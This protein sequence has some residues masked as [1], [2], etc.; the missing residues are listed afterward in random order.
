MIGLLARVALRPHRD[1]GRDRE[2]SDEERGS[3]GADRESEHGQKRAE[4]RREQPRAAEF[5]L[6]QKPAE[7]GAEL[8]TERHL[9]VERVD[10]GEE[11]GDPGCD[12]EDSCRDGCHIQRDIEGL[13][14]RLQ[15]EQG[16]DERPEQPGRSEVEDER[17]GR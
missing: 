3:P 17:R 10:E 14:A 9:G 1:E 16:Q 8:R 15:R 6:R 12:G 2:K 7:L 4:D 11:S 5:G 13:V